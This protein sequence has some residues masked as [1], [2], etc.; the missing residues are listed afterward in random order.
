MVWIGKRRAHSVSSA[1]CLTNSLTVHER[2]RYEKIRRFM[3]LHLVAV[4]DL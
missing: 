4:C 3:A 2:L 1:L